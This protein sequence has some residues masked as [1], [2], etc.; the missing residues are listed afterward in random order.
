MAIITY[1]EAVKEALR[2]EMRRDERVF[3][4]GE[5][6]GIYGGAM[7]VTAGLI[8]EFGPER[9][10]NTPISEAAIA[11]TAVGAAAMGMQVTVFFKKGGGI[12]IVIQL[13][14]NAGL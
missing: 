3:M 7:G 12:L 6:I 13:S 10:R 8:E 2:E 14:Y 5:D 11:G 9:I 1:R 4:L